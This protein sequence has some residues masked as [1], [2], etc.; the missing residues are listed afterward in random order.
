MKTIITFLV[1]VMFMSFGFAQS[2]TTMPKVI[3]PSP[4]ASAFQ[5]YGDMQVSTYTGLPEVSVPLYTVNTGDITLPISLSYHASGI[6]VAD[7][8]SKVGLGW[9]I[10]AGGM[11]SRSIVGGDDFTYGNLWPYHNPSVPE[12]PHHVATNFGYATNVQEG[13]TVNLFGNVVDNQD[14]DSEPDQYYYNLPNGQSGK[15]IL[16]RNKEVILAKDELISI[17]VFGNDASHWQI[18]TQ[19]GFTYEFEDFEFYIG[20]E[21][22]NEVGQH[23]TAWYLSRIISPTGVTVDFKYTKSYNYVKTIGAYTQTNSDFTIGFE[24]NGEINSECPLDPAVNRTVP[25]REYLNVQLDSIKFKEGFIKFWYSSREDILNDQKLHKIEVFCKKSINPVVAERV[26]AID[27]D[28]EYFVGSIDRD[29]TIAGVTLESK[30]LKLKRIF[31][32]SRLD[33][34]G[35]DYKFDYNHED[36]G[37]YPA[38]TSFAR[39]HWGYFNGNFNNGSLIPLFNTVQSSDIAH[40]Y[41]GIMGDQRDS[42]PNMTNLFSLKRIWYP[43][44][45]Y[46]EF[47]FEGNDF[48]IE[49][50]LIRDQSYFSYNPDADSKATHFVYEGNTAGPFPAN[51]AQA[52]Q[53]G[54]VLDLSKAYSDTPNS[55]T[56]VSLNAF[57]RF[58]TQQTQCA[59]GNPGG[60]VTFELVSESG[61]IYSSANIFELLNAPSPPSAACVGTSQPGQESYYGISYKNSYNLPPGKYFWRVNIPASVTLFANVGVSF[62][63]FQRKEGID[64]G[65]GLR[66]KQMLDYESPTATPK[67]TRY[68]YHYWADK[69]GDG[70]A[71]ECSYGRRMVNPNYSY[72]ERRRKMYCETID[73]MTICNE[74]ICESL[75]RSSESTVPLFGSGN[76][77]A[78]DQ[79]TVYYGTNGENGK[80]TFVYHNLPD[81]ALNYSADTWVANIATNVPRRP[82]SS[83]TIAHNLNGM[84]KNQYDFRYVAPNQFDTVKT[85]RNTF[86]NLHSQLS[87]IVWAVEKRRIPSEVTLECSKYENYVYPSLQRTWVNQMSSI[88]KTFD[89]FDQ[90]K[91]TQITT[92]NTYGNF[93]HFLLTRQDVDWEGKHVVTKFKYPLDYQDEQCSPPVLAMKNLQ[94]FYSPLIQKRTE[95]II[96]TTQNVIGQDITQFEFFNSNTMILPRVQ[97]SLLLSA[98]E[99][100]ANVADFLPVNGIDT[101]QYRT[102]FMIN[103][104][105]EG[106]MVSVKKPND[107]PASY[108]WGYQN[109]VPIAEVKNA[110]PTQ[111]FYTSFEDFGEGN[112]VENDSKTGLKSSTSGITRNLTN[113]IPGIYWL[114]YWTKSGG[115]WVFNPTEITVGGTSYQINLAGQV[116]EVRFYPKG[117]LMTTYIYTPMLGI[118]QAIDAANGIVNYEYD[119]FNRLRLIKDA[120][121][122]VVKQYSYNYKI[123]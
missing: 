13:C 76:P 111:I 96:N 66:V 12:L 81:L 49:N 51:F 78:Y 116:D 2:Q 120:D 93:Q 47:E 19:D 27:F 107:A 60:G 35:Y 104:N 52:Q 16:K 101:T 32:K 112:S 31:D 113:L 28:Y 74:I 5:K 4:N 25:G 88:E 29:Y 72:F 110:L 22:I 1:V 54:K 36:D 99:P 121:G 115:S 100:V 30:R 85:I 48:D 105:S 37:N 18:K 67:V 75:K 86:T 59:F 38:K 43:T 103:Y 9:V 62:S 64:F 73:L 39:D 56:T 50:S 102:H 83:S 94:F 41:I 117:A 3:P 71:E 118:T 95:E 122:N 45:G 8:A 46:T 109:T 97:A 20:N 33:K 114:T 98:P 21:L 61:G 26:K 53:V 23:N 106:D 108:I 58:N 91:T 82:P 10:N 77:V 15:F 65:G 84:L 87:A 42:R 40:Y 17:K 63:F 14:Y 7:E 123:K 6:K 57:F 92:T 119:S 80:S 90:F 70:Q 44:G 55:S 34:K 11:V 79:V 69:N 89:Q 24:A 68:D